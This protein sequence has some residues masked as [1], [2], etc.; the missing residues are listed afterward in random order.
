[1]TN[2][3]NNNEIE[4]INEL[5]DFKNI[6][7][8]VTKMYR[9]DWFKGNSGNIAR[10]GQN[11][12][13][14][15]IYRG[16]LY[17]G[18][19]YGDAYSYKKPKATVKLSAIAEVINH[20]G[21]FEYEHDYILFCDYYGHEY[22]SDSY[23]IWTK[24]NILYRQLNNIFSEYEIENIEELFKEHKK[25]IIVNRV[26]APVYDKDDYQTFDDL[27]LLCYPDL[28]IYDD[29][30]Y[31]NFINGDDEGEIWEQYVE[32]EEP[33][34]ICPLTKKE[35]MRCKECP[36][37]TLHI[38][39]YICKCCKFVMCELCNIKMKWYNMRCPNCRN[40]NY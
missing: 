31:Y 38:K 34:K 35:D 40:P 29:L 28:H 15:E 23:V 17:E 13:L 39:K 3:N 12:F 20:E 30:E 16:D 1:M 33:A 36:N 18:F 7:I 26:I 19:Y 8:H 2:T 4:N 10:K 5:D 14:I 24:C 25:D 6:V 21:Q 27:Q 9:G 37:C 11:V 22:D 32:E